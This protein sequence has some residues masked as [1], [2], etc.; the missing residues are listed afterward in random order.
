MKFEQEE[1]EAAEKDGAEAHP[2]GLHTP[3]CSLGSARSPP[4]D[5]VDFGQKRAAVSVPLL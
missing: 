3:L 2:S 4:F 1:A 5:R